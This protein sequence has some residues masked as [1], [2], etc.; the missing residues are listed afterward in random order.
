MVITKSRVRGNTSQKELELALCKKIVSSKLFTDAQK[1]AKRHDALC[2]QRKTFENRLK[3]GI[4]YFI[5]IE[6]LAKIEDQHHKLREK[7]FV[8]KVSAGK[9]QLIGGKIDIADIYEIV[10]NH[11]M[12][13]DVYYVSPYN[14]KQTDPF[15]FCISLSS[16][17]YINKNKEGGPDGF[18]YSEETIIAHEKKH[19]EFYAKIDGPAFHILCNLTNISNEIWQ[20]L[21][22]VHAYSENILLNP[23]EFSSIWLNS[24]E[25]K[26]YVSKNPVNFEARRDLLRC[27]FLKKDEALEDPV[28]SNIIDDVL[29]ADKNL[30]KDK[31]EKYSKGLSGFLKKNQRDVKEIQKSLGFAVYKGMLEKN[32]WKARLGV[33]CK[34]LDE[35]GKA[36]D[37]KNEPSK[38]FYEQF[39]KTKELA[40][41]LQTLA[42][43][44]N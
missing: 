18:C 28:L 15:G 36:S 29:L 6:K 41:K 30:D 17:I 31:I 19:A 3:K 43:E 33:V 22:E 44:K 16:N 4:Y 7:K 40:G 34:K 11:P 13:K 39:E 37:F 27:L 2:M 10:S 20:Y 8:C 21:G 5:L 26:E 14:G 9:K 35:L 23:A 42:F 32:N 38:E 1:L 25:N 24:R 12:H